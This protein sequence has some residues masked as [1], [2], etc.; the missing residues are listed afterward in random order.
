MK[1]VIV[2]IIALAVL[3]F[4][5]VRGGE[6]DFDPNEITNYPPDG[7]TVVAFGDSLVSGIGAKTPGGFVTMLSD[8]LGVPII[9]LGRGGD[10]T[11][12]A[13]DRI[14]E[15][16]ARDPDITL[17]LLGGND[18]LDRVQKEEVFGN[19]DR[20]IVSLH[21]KGSVVVLLGVRGGLLGDGYKDEYKRLAE[22]HNTAYVSD[23]LD[24][25]LGESEY[26]DD[27][28]HPNEAGYGIIAGRVA[29]IM[30]RLLP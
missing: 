14:D 2:I 10:T 26:M 6:T 12:H 11:A 18:Y 8:D 19:L 4:F 21:E 13:L 28:I 25:L 15:V 22:K 24:G 17:V 9:N 29:P 27:A 16:L 30:E 23:V 5:L 1:G 7:N 20:I 3:V